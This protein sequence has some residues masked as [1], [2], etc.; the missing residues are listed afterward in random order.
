MRRTLTFKA[1]YF[2]INGFVVKYTKRV[3]VM[4]WVNLCPAH[5]ARR[6]YPDPTIYTIWV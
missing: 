6:I 5:G 2:I 3:L 1:I 4:H